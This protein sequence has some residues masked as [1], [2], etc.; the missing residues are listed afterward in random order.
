[1]LTI[2][3]WEA[4][5]VLDVL[6]EAQ[7]GALDSDVIEEAVSIIEGVLKTPEIPIEDILK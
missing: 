4:T 1:M 3:R 2:T 5:H 7:G 6:K